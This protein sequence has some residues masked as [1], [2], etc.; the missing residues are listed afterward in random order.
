MQQR[1]RETL[2]RVDFGALL[3]GADESNERTQRRPNDEQSNHEQKCAKAID[4]AAHE[5]GAVGEEV[6]RRRVVDAAPGLDVWIDDIVQRRQTHEKIIKIDVE[7]VD[8]QLKRTRRAKV[9]FASTRR[10]A[11][12]STDL[13][14]RREGVGADRSARRVDAHRRRKRSVAATPSR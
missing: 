7:L 1:Q 5:L 4:L 8:A 2:Q 10:T 12:A 9:E 11:A 3:V 6:A 14:H 13:Q